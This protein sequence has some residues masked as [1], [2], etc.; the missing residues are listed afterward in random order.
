LRF[1][2]LSVE[3]NG[4]IALFTPAARASQGHA[5]ICVGA[6]IPARALSGG[7]SHATNA[8]FAKLLEKIRNQPLC[9]TIFA[10]SVWL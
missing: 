9:R 7:K 5:R 10:K 8:R 2:S 3:E 6:P 4:I 1:Q